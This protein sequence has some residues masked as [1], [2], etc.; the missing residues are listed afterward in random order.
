MVSACPIPHPSP[1]HGPRPP[2]ATPRMVVLH[3][4]GMTSGP[5]ALAR[6]CDPATEVSA[7]YLIEEDG[8]TFQ[9]VAE[10]RRAWHAGRS[11]W[12]GTVDVNGWS[13][14]IELVNPGH[15]WGYRVFPEAQLQAALDLTASIFR[16]HVIAPANLVGHSDIAPA[17]KEDPGELFPWQRFAAAGLGL[18]PEISAAERRSARQLM[19]A[20]RVQEG[21]TRFGYDCPLTG[22]WDAHTEAVVR[23]FQRHYFPRR[24]DGR[25]TAGCAARLVW[26]LEHHLR[27]AGPGY[28]AD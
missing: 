17:R 21:L 14:G 10:D 26:L 4:T 16:R 13:I 19:T 12:R 1:N 22:V 9:L 7:H 15:E 23:A 18:W 11:F 20:A 24:L 25:W 3:Y 28:Q 5:D 8:R 2:G 27:D 6:L